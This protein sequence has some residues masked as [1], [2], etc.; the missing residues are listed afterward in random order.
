MF[1]VR[2]TN[3]KDSTFRHQL[4]LAVSHG[5]K[6]EYLLL[7]AATS[8]E[9]MTWYCLCL[10]EILH[11]MLFQ[12]TKQLENSLYFLHVI[13]DSVSTSFSF[14]W[15]WMPSSKTLRF[16]MDVKKMRHRVQT[17]SGELLRKM[18]HR[19]AIARQGGCRGSWS[20]QHRVDFCSFVRRDGNLLTND[21]VAFPARHEMDDMDP[22]CASVG[23]QRRKIDAKWMLFQ[24]LK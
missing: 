11:F 6:Q 10:M 18:R 19:Y 23:L 22:T 14:L 2:G 12:F 1:K 4:A 17:N 20:W 8:W 16:R 15:P 24:Q 21:E 9:Y 7:V 13:V 5:K 3:S